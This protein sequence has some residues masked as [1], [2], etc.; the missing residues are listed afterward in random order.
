MVNL[1]IMNKK[2]KKQ[3]RKT[4]GQKKRCVVNLN[5]LKLPRNKKFKNA[6]KT[7]NERLFLTCEIS[8]N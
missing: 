6:S 2:K 1:E 3:K 7:D 8:P 4:T 5:V